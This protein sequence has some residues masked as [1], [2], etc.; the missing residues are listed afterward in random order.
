MR[1][2]TGRATRS[3]ES[4]VLHQDLLLSWCVFPCMGCAIFDLLFS[5]ADRA[6]TSTH[7]DKAWSTP[8]QKMQEAIRD[9][10]WSYHKHVINTE[11]HQGPA[12][13]SDTSRAAHVV[14]RRAARPETAPHGD[15]QCQ[16]CHSDPKPLRLPLPS[17]CSRR[18][19]CSGNRKSLDIKL[20]RPK[21]SSTSRPGSGLLPPPSQTETSPL[22][23]KSTGTFV[24]FSETLNPL[25]GPPKPSSL[26]TPELMSDVGLWRSFVGDGHATPL[27]QLPR[28][29]ASI[30]NCSHPRCGVVDVCWILCLSRHRVSRSL[31]WPRLR[32]QIAQRIHPISSKCPRPEK[33]PTLRKSRRAPRMVSSLV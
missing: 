12:N 2:L 29:R 19:R 1:P 21:A 20:T 30:Y 3:D 31:S 6:S 22:P 8:T 26:L 16:Q 10:P 9:T 32:T 17:R 5:A 33:V 27:G 23:S 15:N 14:S 24:G 18:A 25:L 13:C 7:V 28:R 11:T 4:C